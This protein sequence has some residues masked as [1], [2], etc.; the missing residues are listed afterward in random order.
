MK[1]RVSSPLGRRARRSSPSKQL[2]PSRRRSYGGRCFANFARQR[3]TLTAAAAAIHSRMEWPTEE[4]N[5]ENGE[6][7]EEREKKQKKK[8]EERNVS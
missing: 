3:R 8:N 1:Q 6:K 2:A 5:K 4:K 7:E